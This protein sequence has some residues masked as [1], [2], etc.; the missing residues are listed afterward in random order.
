MVDQKYIDAVKAHNDEYPNRRI[1]IDY[2]LTHRGA[3]MKELIKDLQIILGTN[4]D[5]ELGNDDKAAYEAK[6]NFHFQKNTSYPILPTI[7]RA[8]W[9]KGYH[10]GDVYDE[11]YGDGILSKGLNNLIRD[12]GLQD[13]PEFNNDTINFKLLKAIF[14]VDAY[15]LIESKGNPI[16]REMQ[17]TMNKYTYK[18][19]GIYPCDGIPQAKLIRQIVWYMQIVSNDPSDM[20]GEFGDKTLQN[21][22]NNL[23]KNSNSFQ[24]IESVKILECLLNVN[25]IGTLL[26]GKLSESTFKM[27]RQFKTLAN[28]DDPK[29]LTKNNDIT[30]ELVA[31]LLRSCGL[32]SRKTICCDTSFIINQ[33]NIKYLKSEG[34]SIIG[35]YISGT[36]SNRSKALTPGEI[37]LLRNNNFEIFLIFQEGASNKLD[38]FKDSSAGER[39]GNKININM[40]LLNIP[41][42]NVVF[43]A[44][45]CDMYEDDFI[46]YIVPYMEKINQTV[47]KYRIGVYCS[48]L[49]CHILKERNLASAFFISGASYG[50]CGNYGITLPD[51]WHFEQFKTDLKI[52]NLQIDKVAISLNYADCIANFDSKDKKDYTD[53]I[54]KKLNEM[55]KIIN[56]RYS[57]NEKAEFYATIVGLITENNYV[58][59]AVKLANIAKEVKWFFEQVTHRGPWDVKVDESWQKTIGI[60]PMP[61]FGI[62]GGNEYFFF[63]GYYIDREELGNITYG[64]LGTA[65]NFPDIILYIGG[66]VAS[67]GK[68]VHE[69]L[70]NSLIHIKDFKPPYY[71]D[72]KEDHEFVEIGVNLYKKLHNK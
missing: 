15:V 1:D 39:D 33:D 31:G 40:K 30:K 35:R 2:A 63:S 34:Y 16:I 68:K 6:I 37:N 8:M 28:L 47:K 3:V 52:G 29:Q 7:R 66:G 72:S 22:L 70:L 50:F 46:K 42:N 9:C 53:I 21:Y 49:G 44:I 71:G 64:Y 69:M 10:G 13:I 43:V 36:V 51:L 48:R 23:N 27:I 45:D 14:S 58:V 62:R 4:P 55:E 5:G 60:T 17:Q 57:E 20:D 41:E 12:A 11:Q 61:R 59:P 24:Y 32:K 18:Y 26:T 19:I 38:Y 25:R 65:M 67:K 56:E 54:M